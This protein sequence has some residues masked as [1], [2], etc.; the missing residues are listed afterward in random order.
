MTAG[1]TSASL[2]MALAAGWNGV[3]VSQSPDQTMEMM[4]VDVQPIDASAE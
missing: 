1:M 3:W 4:S 2:V